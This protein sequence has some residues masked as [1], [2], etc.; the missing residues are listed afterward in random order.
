MTVFRIAKRKY[1]DDVSG[2]GAR[3]YGGRWNS[4]GTS[5][6]YTAENRAL[7]TIEY[8]VHIPISLLPVDTFIAEIQIPDEID[9]ERIRVETLPENWASNPPPMELAKLGEE[10]ARRRET[11]VLRVPSAV[12]KEEWNILIN[13]KHELADKVIVASIEPVAFDK[14]LL[15]SIS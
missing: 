7:A 9:H 10:W 15:R 6:V 14:R 12:V 5:V 3:L 1:I 11:L 13:P 4:K 2:E 8:L